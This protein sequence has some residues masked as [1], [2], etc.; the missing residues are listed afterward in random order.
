VT[1]LVTQELEHRLKLWQKLIETGETQEVRPRRLREL[2]IYGGAQGIW[3]DKNRTQR[4][5]QNQLGVTVGL[6]HTGISYADDLTD[7]GVIY[8]YP[9][10][11]RGLGKDLAEV[12]STKMATTLGLPIFVITP[13]RTSALR[14]VHLAWVEDWDDRA[15][16]FLISFG[17]NPPQTNV[18][19]L[20]QDELFSL[21]METVQRRYVHLTS[22]LVKL[23]EDIVNLQKAGRPP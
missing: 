15:K 10:T 22:Q 21:T 14:T 18:L 12:D 4:V 7:D 16:R 23:Q 6:L 9:A 5:T 1:D 19:G 3:I 20:D 13:G 2:G 17:N 11:D 8:H